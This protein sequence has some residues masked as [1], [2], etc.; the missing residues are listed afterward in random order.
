MKGAGADCL[1]LLLGVY[2]ELTGKNAPNLIPNYSKDWAETSGQETLLEGCRQT[3]QE[4]AKDAW[5]EGDVVLFRFRDYLPAKH[6]GIIT[7]MPSSAEPRFVHSYDGAE[8]VAEGRLS[9][10]WRDRIAFAF[11]FPGVT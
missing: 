4:I 8:F 2:R 6:C 11:Q 3:L 7:A 1:G 9:H 10:W 5:R